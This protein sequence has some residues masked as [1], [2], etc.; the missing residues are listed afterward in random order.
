MTS[1]PICCGPNDD[2]QYALLLMREHHVRRIPVV[3]SEGRICG[4]ISFA[5]LVMN[6]VDPTQMFDMI[7]A[8]SVPTPETMQ[9]KH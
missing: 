6:H 4:M 5:N 1:A 9:I 3:D 2:L 7:K 8:V